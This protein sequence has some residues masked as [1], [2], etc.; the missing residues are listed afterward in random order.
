MS[1]SIMYGQSGE[2]RYT[3]ALPDLREAHSSGQ[4]RE[5][6]SSGQVRGHVARLTGGKH[7]GTDFN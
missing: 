7:W 5:A 1:N 4:V 3:L 6:H 2:K